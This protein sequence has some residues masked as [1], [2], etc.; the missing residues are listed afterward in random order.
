MIQWYNSV[1][2]NFC[3]QSP[4]L[5]AAADLVLWTLVSYSVS[6]LLNVSPAE[7]AP[8]L[9]VILSAVTAKKRDGIRKLE[10]EISKEFETTTAESSS[11]TTT[12]PAQS[13]AANTS[14]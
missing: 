6:Y 5:A 11:E 12:T 3:R 7:F 9:T 10:Y 13:D 4:A 1:Y 8:L 2:Q 14:N